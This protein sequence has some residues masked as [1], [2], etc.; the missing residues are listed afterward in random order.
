[1]H[2]SQ[3]A[4]TAT[5]AWSS[6]WTGSPK[7][8]CRMHRPSVSVV[9]SG[10]TAIRINAEEEEDWRVRVQVSSKVCTAADCLVGTAVVV[11]AAG[12]VLTTRRR[13]R[14]WWGWTRNYGVFMVFD[15]IIV[16]VR[17]FHGCLPCVATAAA[18]SSSSHWGCHC[19][20]QQPP[21]FELAC[22]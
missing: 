6:W 4:L 17:A 10:V 12:L 22:L 13:W 9:M 14:W 18:A 2:F 21:F 20:C 7:V 19:R 1:M 16:I 15:M 3:S 11:G 8:A 5:T